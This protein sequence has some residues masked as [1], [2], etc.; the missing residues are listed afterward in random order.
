MTKTNRLTARRVSE[1]PEAL[2][3]GVLYVADP[4]KMAM[5][6]C[7]CG[8]G[9]EVTTRYGAGGWSLML[10]G[11]VPT[12]T[13]SIGPSTQKCRSHYVV[14]RGQVH[15]LE[16]MSAGEIAAS[17]ARDAH[18]RAVEFAAAARAQA[19]WYIRLL[20]WLGWLK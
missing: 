19:P 11:D 15:W 9:G 13:P 18:K 20:R 4:F 14:S 12:I 7:C 8:C 1:V 3:P 10:E 6:L 2:A 17:R 5:H 16:D